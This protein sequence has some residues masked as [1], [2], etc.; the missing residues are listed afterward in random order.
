MKQLTRFWLLVVVCGCLASLGNGF[1][2]FSAHSATPNP[3]LALPSASGGRAGGGGRR[4]GNSRD[5][6]SSPAEVAASYARFSSDLQREESNAD[7]QRTCRD[8]AEQN[9]H[10]ILPELEFA[11]AALDDA[12]AQP[13]APAKDQANT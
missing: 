3:P 12:A 4:R 1:S 8:A 11:D 9:G 7:Q 6:T 2:T 10:Q 5:T 13:K